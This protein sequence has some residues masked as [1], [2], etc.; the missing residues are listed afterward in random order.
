MVKEKTEYFFYNIIELLC[1][2]PGYFKETL[3]W[4]LYIIL[5]TFT[6]IYLTA[7]FKCNTQNNKK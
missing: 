4:T 5:N 1:S 2:Y 6:S 7:F 3:L